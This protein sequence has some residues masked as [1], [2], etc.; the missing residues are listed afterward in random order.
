[1]QTISQLCGRA[2]AWASLRADGE[3]SDLESAL[4][5]AHLGRCVECHAFA[6]SAENVAA[7][8]RS[9]RL[10]RPAP[11]VLAPAHPHRPGVIRTLQ[12]AAA[13]A[14]VVAVGLVAS[15]SGPRTTATAKPVVMVAGSESSD[16]LRELRRP[17]LVE[18][19]H[20]LP[21]NRFVPGVAV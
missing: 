15:A 1:M 20:S 11:F 5:E 9:M 12:L 6:L 4:L 13:A 21:R 8:L 7:A 14:V 2:R 19:G 16:G 10:E 18:K 3:L 17:A